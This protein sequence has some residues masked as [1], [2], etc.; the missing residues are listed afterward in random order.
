MRSL[1][2]AKPFEGPVAG[3]RSVAHT[4]TPGA[5]PSVVRLL[6]PCLVVSFMFGLPTLVVSTAEGID[7]SSGE[8][9][10]VQQV[11]YS[12]GQKGT[13]LKWLPHRPSR[14]ATSQQAAMTRVA[15][16][17]L[18]AATNSGQPAAGS[19]FDNPFGDTKPKSPERAQS[20]SQPA[21]GPKPDEDKEIEEPTP[22][23]RINTPGSKTGATPPVKKG[24]IPSLDEAL[25][26]AR[27]IEDECPS[28]TDLKPIS[29]ITNDISAEEGDF[30]RIC[31][32]G[33][34][35]YES[36]A[37]APVTFSWTASGLCHKP[38]YFEE[39]HLERYG[40]SCGPYVQPVVSGAHFFLTVPALPYLMGLTPPY[41]CMYTLGYYRPGSCAPYMLD[42]LPISVRAA[43][44]EAGVWT[45]MVYLIP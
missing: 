14:V 33:D 31:S 4:S 15:S 39:T 29:E 1:S 5:K 38:L 24:Q 20:R 10:S 45:G 40:H 11:S 8:V 2:T 3:N 18:K 26:T 36:R 35:T 28:V 21:T 7:N 37:W 17:Q 23:P 41:E 25:A 16:L 30:P 34:A 12:T 13:K 44:L 19:P 22:T 43:L 6:L 27:G 32:L 42:P 9:N